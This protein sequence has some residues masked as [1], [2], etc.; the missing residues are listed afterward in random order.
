MNKYTTKEFEEKLILVCKTSP[1]MASACSAL[2]MHFTTFKTHAERLGVY[3]PNQSGKGVNKKSAKKIPLENIIHFGL[4]PQYQTNKL[5]IRLLNEG[6]KLHQCESCG[7]A[8]WSNNPIPLELDH[9]DGCNNN[10]LIDN[11]RLL[12]PNCHAFT[13]T[14]RGRNTKYLN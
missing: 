6:I 8:T 11:L 2:N 13:P 4:H 10:H 3:N 9:I 12:C 7:L 5:R 14:Y 1:S